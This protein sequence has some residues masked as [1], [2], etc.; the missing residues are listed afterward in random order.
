MSRWYAI[1]SK[2]DKVWTIGTFGNIEKYYR[3]K[4]DYVV[5]GP[6][7]SGNKAELEA[8]CMNHLVNDPEYLAIRV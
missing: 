5:L 1:G 4:E 3:A 6:Y 7:R 2:E 8:I